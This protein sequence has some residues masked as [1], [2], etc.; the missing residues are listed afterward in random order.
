[1][2]ESIRPKAPEGEYSLRLDPKTTL[3]PE[4][5]QAGK[6]MLVLYWHLFN[7]PP[8]VNFEDIKDCEVR[9]KITLSP[10]AL[11]SIRN[12]LW[13]CDIPLEC[14][15]CKTV[16]TA[17][18]DGCPN[19]KKTLF[20]FESELIRTKH[21]RAFVNQEKAFQSENIVNSIVKYTKP[22]S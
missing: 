10:N 13:A 2:K 21:P 3:K 11:F 14:D 6:P 5:S 4:N 17:D 15:S 20:G 16:Y 12:L 19:C 7:P 1:M 22:T 18:L 8:G 9:D